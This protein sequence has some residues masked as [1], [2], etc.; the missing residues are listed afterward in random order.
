MNKRNSTL[1]IWL[2][3]AVLVTVATAANYRI[4]KAAVWQI[5]ELK[6]GSQFLNRDGNDIAAQLDVLDTID[7]TDLA[8]IDGITNGTIAASKA[9]VVDANKDVTGFRNL[10]CTGTI[11]TPGYTYTAGAATPA[12]GLR[13]GATATEG[14]EIKVY[15]ETVELTNAAKTDTTLAVP[16][17]AVLLCVQANLAAA[18]T[19]DASG[20]DLLAKIGIGVSGGDEDKYGETSGLTK[21]LKVDTIPDWAVNAGETISIFGL[22][23]DG[24]TACTEK[25]TGGSGQTV[26]VRVVYA[27]PN[28]LDD[29][30]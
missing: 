1:A 23:A 12:V 15:D 20:D 10:T 5:F 19:G 6:A 26:R 28:S 4:D 27:V 11:A 7:A 21:N 3:V 13:F 30:T 22:K 16:A 8:K 18:I 24:N 2:T 9:V 25:F 29:A 17:G 14:L